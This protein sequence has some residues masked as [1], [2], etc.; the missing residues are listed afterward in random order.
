MCD[1]KE[2]K[3]VHLAVRGAERRALSKA[4]GL[5][6]ANLSGRVRCPNRQAMSASEPAIPKRAATNHYIEYS[7]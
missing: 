4:A 2:E 1:R 5:S 7:F 3:R 6:G